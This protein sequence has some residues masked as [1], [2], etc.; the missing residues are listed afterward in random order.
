[1][2]A[3]VGFRL[4]Q[5][6]PDLSETATAREKSLLDR[7]ANRAGSSSFQRRLMSELFGQV[8]NHVRIAGPQTE[9]DSAIVQTDFDRQTRSFE[10][11]DR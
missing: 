4:C 1:M 11:K 6:E 5:L 7:Q 3:I 2:I 8:V 9:D 10:R